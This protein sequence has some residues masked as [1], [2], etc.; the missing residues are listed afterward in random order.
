MRR[1]GLLLVL[2]LVSATAAARTPV[3]DRPVPMSATITPGFNAGTLV[4]SAAST[5]ELPVVVEL[6]GAHIIRTLRFPSSPATT[7]ALDEHTRDLSP[8]QYVVRITRGD[9]VAE[10]TTMIHAK[11]GLY[12]ASLREPTPPKPARRWPYGLAAL[13]LLVV[14]GLRLVK[15]AGTADTHVP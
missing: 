11:C 15:R 3:L 12:Y 8:G 7:F 9:Q 5:E 13:A 2:L 1:H 4:L 10:T 6:E 14:V